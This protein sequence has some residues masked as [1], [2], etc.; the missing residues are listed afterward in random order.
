[1]GEF[2]CQIE[3]HPDGSYCVV[4]PEIPAAPAVPT[5]TIV[6]PQL[7]WNA[8][9]HST[10]SLTGDV[11]TQFTIPAN[12]VGVVCGL[13]PRHIDS[14]P[15]NM[16]FAIYA[17]SSAGRSYWR[18]FEAGVAKTAP[19]VRVPE[20]DVF[21]IERRGQGVRY[22]FNGRQY[23]VSAATYSGALRVVACMYA[24]QD[25]VN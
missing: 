4:C 14:R 20:T 25:G 7:G 15:V 6:D 13:A 2:D 21:R 8:S 23:Y 12:V 17:Y 10:Q 22:F 19:V 16:P 3:S 24:A 5:Q 9:A 18:V 11:Y 1:V